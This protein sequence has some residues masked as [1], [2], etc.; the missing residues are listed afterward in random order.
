MKNRHRVFIGINLPPDIKK[1]LASYQKKWSDL[2]VKWVNEDNLHITLTFLG[3]L[4]DTEI[5]EVS[6][7]LKGVV[8]QYNS[9]ELHLREVVY[10]PLQQSLGQAP[11]MIWANGEKSKQLSLLKRDLERAIS[12]RVNFKPEARTL[13][14]HVTLARIKTF[15]W[16]AIDTVEERPEFNEIIDLSFDVGSIEIMESVLRKTGPVY[17]II[18]SHPLSTE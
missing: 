9:F 5:G 15:E 1:F 2:P 16:R 13:S 11:K 3:Y 7:A 4:T 10:W 12:E 17:T 6:I 14:P 8:E 18:E